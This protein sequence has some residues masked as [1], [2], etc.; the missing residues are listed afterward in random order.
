[1]H[2]SLIIFWA[3]YHKF[4]IHLYFTELLQVLQQLHS[5]FQRW[6]LLLLQPL[7]AQSYWLTILQELVIGY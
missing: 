4:A 6:L 7:Q 5:K 1:M 2:G 3:M